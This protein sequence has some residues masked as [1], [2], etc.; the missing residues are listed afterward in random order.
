[1]ALGCVQGKEGGLF[2]PTIAIP[3]FKLLSKSNCF[4]DFIAATYDPRITWSMFCSDVVP[5]S[6]YLVKNKY[7][8][9]KKV[10]IRGGS[11]GGD[12]SNCYGSLLQLTIIQD[13]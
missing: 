5:S 6:D 10:A 8:D 9:P 4:D 7:C 1:M 2:D 3:Q 11:N 13:C 12:S